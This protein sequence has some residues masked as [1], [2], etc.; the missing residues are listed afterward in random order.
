MCGRNVIFEITS[1]ERLKDLREGSKKHNN[2]SALKS[3]VYRCGRFD[4]FYSKIKR[5]AEKMLSFM[6]R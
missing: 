3:Q 1:A 5:S 2:F 4:I 6:E